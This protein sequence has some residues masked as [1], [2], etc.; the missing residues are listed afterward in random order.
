MGSR[1]KIQ[2]H[3]T[4]DC[5]SFPSYPIVSK[6]LFVFKSRLGMCDFGFLVYRLIV[7]QS[8]T[9]LSTGLYRKQV[10]HLSAKCYYVITVFDY[11]LECL[12]S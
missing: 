9:Y 7:N 8:N 11:F 12:F 4:I 10:N 2:L 3:G 6:A 5:L 1:E